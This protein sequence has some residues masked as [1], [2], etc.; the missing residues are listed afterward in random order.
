M[1]DFTINDLL[2]RRGIDLRHTRLVRHDMRGLAEWRLGVSFFDH[3]ASY[4]RDDNRTPYNQAKIAIQFVPHSLS[5]ALFVGAH[6]ILDEWQAAHQPDRNPAR[7]NPRSKY[8]A[9][10]LNHRRYDLHRRLDMED[11]VGRLVIDWGA[12]T[13]SWSQWTLRHQKPIIELRASAEDDP[14]PGFSK[15]SSTIDE[16]MLLPMSWQNALATVNGVYLLVCPKT[17]EQYVGSA[18]GDQGFM[19]RWAAYA[20]NGHGGNRLLMKRDR[21]NYAV[22]ILE[23]ASPDM[24]PSEIIDREGAW[25][26]KLGTRSHGLNAN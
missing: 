10:D 16:V 26:R 6:D 15:F 9:Q 3:F 19:A 8:I 14:F 21:V 13:R 4:Q 24:S 18:Y 2:E 20:A 22:S 11:L 23:I 7:F 17:G 5:G 25:K 12:S 1:H